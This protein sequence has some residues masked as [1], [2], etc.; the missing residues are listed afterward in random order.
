MGF[1]RPLLL[2]LL[3]LPAL[4]A[5]WESQRRGHR[6]VLPLD[7]GVARSSRWLKRILSVTTLFP[8]LLLAVAVVMLAGPRRLAVPENERV[9]SNIYFC[10]DVSGSMTSPFGDGSRYDAAMN[11][12]KEFTTFRKGD[13]F[14]L[15]IFGNEVLHWVPLTQDLSAIRFSTPF[16]RP[17]KM[18]PWFGGTQIGKALRACRRVLAAKPE[19][20]RMIILVSDG[21]SADLFGGQ[22][23]EIGNELSLDKI[24]LFYIHAAEGSPQPECETIA[25][26]TGG[27]VFAASDPFSLRE[28]FRRI[29]SMQPAK[30]KPGAPEFADFL[31][32]L[33]LIGLGVLGLQVTGQFGLRYTP[34]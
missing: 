18:P 26:A 12:I 22:A 29:D 25:A 8:A 11:A 19:G 3:V 9:L 4:L 6:I 21:M 32:P 16:L 28:I 27:A 23:E 15:T 24:T 31:W 13:A 2:L 14:G 20:D 7:H 30:V 34:W 1:S 33:A 10:L 17:D 5:V